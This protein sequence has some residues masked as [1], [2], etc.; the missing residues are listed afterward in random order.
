MEVVAEGLNFKLLLC[1]NAC[2][3]PKAP[4][5]F[6]GAGEATIAAGRPSQRW[7]VHF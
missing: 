4:E 2:L 7:W 3:I 1:Q 5:T 6:L